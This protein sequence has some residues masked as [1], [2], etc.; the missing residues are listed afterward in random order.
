MLQGYFAGLTDER[1][2]GKIK[3]NLLEIVV[4]TICAV[5]AGCDVWEDIADFCRVKE[6]WFKESL[7]MKLENGI[8]S[9]DTMQRVWEMIH[10]EELERCFRSWVA[11]VCQRIKG[12][13]INIDG[14]TI[15]GSADKDKSP[16]HMVSAWAHQQQ[17]VLGQLV[18][19]EKSNEITAVPNL[20]N[21]LDIAGCIVTAD[22]MSCQKEITR[23]IVEK[24]ADYVIGLKDNQPTLR[25][26]T[27]DYFSAALADRNLYPDIQH[28][29]TAE[30]GH[31]RIEIR[32]YYLTTDLGWLHGREEW[33]GLN[34]LGLV[35]AKVIMGK[36]VSEENRLYITS[37]TDT[38]QFANA[39]RAH[40]GIENSLHWCLDMTFHED[41]SRIRKDHS[42]ENMAVV[43]HLVLDILK[44]F[45]EKISLA[46]KRRRCSY[47]DAFLANVLLS[48][49]A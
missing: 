13:I 6:M 47:D 34:G 9:H 45:P 7:S 48:I 1:Q 46:R 20:L 24:K 14:K 5:I 35:H 2:S 18:T 28:F 37:L 49:H 12:E 33:G 39:V 19:N 3:H 32:D 40:W 17:F 41:Y 38:K 31:G 44:Q 4:M 10:P 21:M 42:P 36:K 26:D 16:I 25:R 30:K 15:C 43:R 22:A 29:Q 23:R 27:A 8:P 11:S